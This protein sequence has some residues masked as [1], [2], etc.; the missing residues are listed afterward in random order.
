MSCQFNGT[1]N[2]CVVKMY[3]HCNANV[4]WVSQHISHQQIGKEPQAAS[5]TTS[6]SCRQTS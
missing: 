5:S 1:I 2:A 6:V 3:V 4:P